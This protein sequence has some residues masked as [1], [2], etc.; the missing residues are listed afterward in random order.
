MTTLLSRTHTPSAAIAET[1]ASGPART[2]AQ[3]VFGAVR[4]G[5]GWTFLWAFLDKTFGWGFST[6]DA[7]AWVNE[8]HPTAGFLGH[9]EGPFASMWKDAAGTWWANWLFMA[10]L[11][12]IGIAL[13]LGIGMR[14]AAAAGAL[15]FVLMWSVM[16]P[17][18]TNPFLDDHLISAGVLIGLALINAGATLGLGRQWSQTGLV[19]R[20]RWLR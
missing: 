2:A 17:P 12:A 9:A 10:G 1:R 3:Y 7:N 11:A 16:L 19:R 18:T 4:I 6:T 20:L 15:L 14:I 8:G 13:I 5:L